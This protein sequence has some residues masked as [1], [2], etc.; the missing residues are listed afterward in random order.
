MPRFLLL[1]VS[2][3]FGF[4]AINEVPRPRISCSNARSFNP[5]FQAQ[6]Q[7]WDLVLQRCHWS[8][9]TP[10]GTPRGL[11]F[12]ASLP[13]PFLVTFLQIDSNTSGIFNDNDAVIKVDSAVGA[14]CHLPHFSLEIITRSSWALRD[15][16][17]QDWD[18]LRTT[19]EWKALAFL[20]SPN[21]P[22][23][24]PT[25]NTEHWSY[26]LLIIW[27]LGISGK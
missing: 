21:P 4:L 24:K 25:Q 11:V 7:T 18:C 2:S 19:G 3:F 6:D 26:I 15:A 14:T 20:F 17:C 23:P 10:E 13:A 8:C 22:L 1:F 16:W 27:S 12:E 9:C 5:L